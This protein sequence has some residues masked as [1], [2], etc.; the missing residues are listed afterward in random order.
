MGVDNVINPG[1]T[2]SHRDLSMACYQG[3][4][5]GATSNVTL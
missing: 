4:H 3:R 1:G 2:F 5:F